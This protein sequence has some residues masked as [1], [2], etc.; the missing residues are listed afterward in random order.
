MIFATKEWKGY[1]QEKPSQIPIVF[2]EGNFQDYR[3]DIAGLPHKK[4]Y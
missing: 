2:A 3:L 1:T 4:G